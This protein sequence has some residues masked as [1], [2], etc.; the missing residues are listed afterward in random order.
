[1]DCWVCPVILH[2]LTNLNQLYVQFQTQISLSFCMRIQH[3]FIKEIF[4]LLGLATNLYFTPPTVESALFTNIREF[5]TKFMDNE[6][7]GRFFLKQYSHA[8]MYMEAVF[9]CSLLPFHLFLL[10]IKISLPHALAKLFQYGHQGIVLRPEKLG[11]YSLRWEDT[12][13][14]TSTAFSCGSKYRQRGAQLITFIAFH[15]DF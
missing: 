11:T 14:Q 3:K 9:L 5:I 6:L 1:M 10:V 2:L 13:C 4:L 15:V 12:A 7:K 8:C